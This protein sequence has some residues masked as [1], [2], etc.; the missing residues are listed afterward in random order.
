MLLC[1]AQLLCWNH[2]I[3]VNLWQDSDG[4]PLGSAGCNGSTKLYWSVSKICQIWTRNWQLVKTMAGQT[5]FNRSFIVKSFVTLVGPE[6]CWIFSLWVCLRVT[7]L[8]VKETTKLLLWFSRRQRLPIRGKRLRRDSS[9]DSSWQENIFKL[10]SYC[11]EFRAG[12]NLQ[13]KST[14]RACSNI[15][16]S[17]FSFME[18]EK[19]S[20]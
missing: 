3:W 13:W 2:W 17:F 14:S 4:R 9:E 5:V 1:W 8:A 19:K 7:K 16:F 6:I 15:L 11:I 12:K 10:E 20:F 18:N